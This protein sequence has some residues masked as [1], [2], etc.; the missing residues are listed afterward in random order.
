MTQK[1]RYRLQILLI[2][3]LFSINKIGIGMQDD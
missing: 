1:V 3:N 2:N